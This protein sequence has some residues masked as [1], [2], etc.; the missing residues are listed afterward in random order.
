GKFA[1]GGVVG[2]SDRLCFRAAEAC[3]PA[4]AAW[5]PFAGR[6]VTLGIRPEAVAVESNGTGDARLRLEVDL[7]ENVGNSCLVTLRR[8]QWRGTARAG[9][10]ADLAGGPTGEGKVDMRQS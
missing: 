8:Q 7:V 5:Q 1:G 2:E 3:L 4:P 6:D 10:P 9:A